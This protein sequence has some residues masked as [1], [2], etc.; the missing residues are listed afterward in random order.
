MMFVKHVADQGEMIVD[1][2]S[3]LAITWLN[4]TD[5]RGYEAKLPRQRGVENQH[6]PDI[7]I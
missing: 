4:S 5:R 6:I 3:L 7:D 1:V 2:S